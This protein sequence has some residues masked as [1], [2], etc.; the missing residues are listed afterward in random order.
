MNPTPNE[1][2]VPPEGY[3]II[4]HDWL[5]KNAAP[6]DMLYFKQGLWIHSMWANDLIPPEIMSQF[7]YATRAPLPASVPSGGAAEQEVCQACGGQGWWYAGGAEEPVQVQCE[8]CNATGYITPAPAPMGETPETAVGGK[9]W[10]PDFTID[11]KPV[12][13]SLPAALQNE[14]DD[15][16]T[17]VVAVVREIITERDKAL[18]DLSAVRKERDEAQQAGLTATARWAESDAKLQADISA[19]REKVDA[20]AAEIG[21]ACA[22]L[23]LW[24]NAAHP[25]LGNIEAARE[26]LNAAIT[27]YTGKEAT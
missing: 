14:M 25:H 24:L 12:D 26:H 4:P 15:L 19:L 3:R 2:P 17:E 13:I 27:T 1:V 11:K 8:S 18:A 20:M 16:R 7:H 6:R 10:F 22:E 9:R 21:K 23:L 5:E